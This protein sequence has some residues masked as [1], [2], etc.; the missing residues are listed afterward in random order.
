M[1]KA[2]PKLLL[3]N[4]QTLL[5]VDAPRAVA[6]IPLAAS[7]GKPTVAPRRP[8]PGSPPQ[9]P[10]RGNV[11]TRPLPQARREN[12]PRQPPVE[13]PAEEFDDLEV[14]EVGEIEFGEGVDEYM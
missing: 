14:P 13:D 7:K 6:P 1:K 2:S 12:S 4:V 5:Y 8:A 3:F 10:G 11:T 9:S